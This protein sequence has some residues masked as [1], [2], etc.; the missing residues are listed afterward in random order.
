MESFGD[1]AVPAWHLFGARFH[2]SKRQ[3]L[4]K[5]EMLT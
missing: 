4:Q 5:Q 2:Y 1:A 3:H